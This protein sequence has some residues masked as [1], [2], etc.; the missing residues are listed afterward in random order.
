NI[1]ITIAENQLLAI[2]EDFEIVSR[3]ID[4]RY[5]DYKKIIPTKFS[6]FVRVDKK[7]LDKNIRMASVFSSSISDVRLGFD[8]GEIK[9]TAK[10]SD[11]GEINARL[12]CDLKNEPFDISVNYHYLLD[13]LRAISSDNILIEFV[14][15]NAPIVVRGENIK[16]QIYV[17]MPLRA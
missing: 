16:D 4:G 8:K 15:N 11:R 3:L 1:T 12:V 10:N 6:S 13:G 2:G 7:N 17:I 5:P 9:I 14:S